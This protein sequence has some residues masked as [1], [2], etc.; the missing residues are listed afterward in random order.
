MFPNLVRSKTSAGNIS[1]SI[2]SIPREPKGNCGTPVV[3]LTENGSQEY[4][5]TTAPVGLVVDGEGGY[6]PEPLPA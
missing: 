2:A 1:P 4:A 5:A 3:G 6:P